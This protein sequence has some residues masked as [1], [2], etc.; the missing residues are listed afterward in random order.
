MIE[1]REEAEALDRADPLR[2]FRAQFEL[3]PG[4][5]YLDGNSLGA[6]CRR[7]RERIAGVVEREWGRDLIRS[8]N[9]ADWISMPQRVGDKIARLVGAG[10]GEVVAADSTSV[11]LFKALSVAVRVNAG[12]R[13]IVSEKANFPTDLYVV[14]GLIEQLGGGLELVLVDGSEDAIEAVLAQRGA[15]VGVVFLTHIHY[16]TSRMYDMRRVTAAAHRAGAVVVWDLSHSAG[17]VPVDLNGCDVDFAVG[18]G[19]KHL[20]GGPGAPAFIFAARRFHD[21]AAQPISGWMGDARPFDFHPGYEPAVGISRWLS[22]TPA[23]VTM[24]GLEAS[25]EVI[26]EAPMGEIRRKSVALCDAFIELVDR[27]C[28]GFDLELVSA[29]DGTWRGSHLSYRHPESYPVMQALISGGVIGD[30][31]PPDLM[32][33]GFAPLYLR[34]VEVWDAVARIA[35]VLR[36]RAWD[37]PQFRDRKAVT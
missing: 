36:N 27:H 18:C 21:R 26:L 2:E 1:S 3:P 20:N 13:V 14:Q 22:G 15:E 11:N 12:R 37:R 23:I 17:V 35:E 10:E 6:L 29:R 19:Y 28:A 24:A 16:T 25:V 33:F 30:C 4:V 31:R 8:W 5:I 7:A 34:Y 32:R 9:G